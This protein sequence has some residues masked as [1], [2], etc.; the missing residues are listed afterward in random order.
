MHR[1]A[2]VAISYRKP[3]RCGGAVPYETFRGHVKALRVATLHDLGRITLAKGFPL[4]EDLPLDASLNRLQSLR[5]LGI[6][7]P[8]SGIVTLPWGERAPVNFERAIREGLPVETK[9]NRRF[10][11]TDRGL[12]KGS[13]YS[14]CDANGDDQGTLCRELF[15]YRDSRLPGMVFVADSF[16][17]KLNWALNRSRRFKA[18]FSGVF[19]VFFPPITEG[20]MGQLERRAWNEVYKDLIARGAISDDTV[21]CVILGAVHN[22][23]TIEKVIDLR[24]RHVQEWFFNLFAKGDGR[25]FTKSYGG[26]IDG[27][28]AMLPTLMH[29][30]FGGA[31]VTDCIGNWMRVNGVNALIYPSARSDASVRYRRGDLIGFHGW[32]LVDYRKAQPLEHVCT[33]LDP[34][35][36][37]FVQP[38][39]HVV[40]KTS[41]PSSGSWQVV[42]IEKAYT[43]I[44]RACFWGFLVARLGVLISP[45]SK[46]K[47]PNRNSAQATGSTENLAEEHP[48]DGTDMMRGLTK[49]IEAN[50]LFSQGVLCSKQSRLQQALTYFDRVEALLKEFSDP[51]LE[52]KVKY[53]RAIIWV[54]QGRI[55]LAFD[56]FQALRSEVSA[57]GNRELEADTLLELGLIS[58]RYLKDLDRAERFYN[59][60]LQVAAEMTSEVIAIHCRFGL[61]NVAA[62]QGLAKGSCSS[63]QTASDLYR[64]CIEESEGHDELE[65][66]CLSHIRYARCQLVL[67]DLKSARET[68]NEVAMLLR[69]QQLNTVERELASLKLLMVGARMLGPF[70]RWFSPPNP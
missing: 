22:E 69:G 37:K 50:L 28:A 4:F 59:Q 31:G 70:W 56:M 55:Q 5:S 62:E 9:R 36:R 6:D 68:T 18:G 2:G 66:C 41:G 47:N 65:L 34:W 64:R 61:A 43:K 14:L 15:E 26:R 16:D 17:M 46:D 52:L 33:D 40:E 24:Q 48:L 20:T 67:G 1:M 58:C 25:C 21:G 10:A 8:E 60:G 11:G 53:E 57:T 42:G 30:E 23:Y 35:F 54:E 7:M 13:Y 63:Y 38:G 44:R 45:R 49:S 3:E 51:E 29:P 19:V 27:F 12:G 32:N 39:A